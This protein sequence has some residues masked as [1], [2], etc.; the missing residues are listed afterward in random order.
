MKT[1]SI[2]IAS[3]ARYAPF[4]A[5]G[6]KWGAGALLAMTM[7]FGNLSVAWGKDLIYTPTFSSVAVDGYDVT[8]YFNAAEPVKGNAAF[9]TEYMGAEWH[10]ASQQNLDKFLSDPQMYAPQYGGYCAWA[11]SQGGTAKGD[12][13][14][15]TVHQGKLY[16][17]YNAKI[18][19]KWS[20]D[21]DNLIATANQKW[22][23]VLQ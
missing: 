17:N 10:F 21:K 20:R 18:N 15:W 7:T 1:S 23:A 13:L 11:V 22:P 9:Q 14:Q 19:K 2:S 16:L 5:N 3:L 6:V 4:A 12:P 8:E